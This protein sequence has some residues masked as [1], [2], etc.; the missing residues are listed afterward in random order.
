[1][2]GNLK[3]QFCLTVRHTCQTETKVD[4]NDL[5]VLYGKA[6]TQRIKATLGITGSSWMRVL[7]ESGVRHL[8]VDSSH[9]G[10]VAVSKGWSVR[11]LKRYVSWVQ[12]VV[13]QVGP[14]VLKM[15]K[16][17]KKGALVR[18]DRIT[19]TSGVSAIFLKVSSN[20]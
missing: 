8:D 1:M 7:T 15:L 16:I 14:S 6:S 10:C 11:P 5:L 2:Q 19:I 18:K 9:P 12:T 4:F 20:S 3:I 13:R 17:E